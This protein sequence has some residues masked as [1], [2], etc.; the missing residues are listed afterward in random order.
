MAYQ[1]KQGI[2]VKP[3]MNRYIN[4]FLQKFGATQDQFQESSGDEIEMQ[5]YYKA[6]GLGAVINDDQFYTEVKPNLNVL[7]FGGSA[8]KPMMDIIV[9]ESD[10]DITPEND[11]SQLTPTA[12][13]Q[14]MEEQMLRDMQQ[15]IDQDQKQGPEEDDN[16]VL[17]EHE[18]IEIQ[19]LEELRHQESKLK[20]SFPRKTENMIVL[21]GQSPS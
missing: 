6:A 2:E 16:N 9:N 12:A 17:S 7:F 5:Q 4:P 21:S 10:N 1:R 3:N 11:I 20:H 19:N 18:D 13:M 15:E 14:R 8:I